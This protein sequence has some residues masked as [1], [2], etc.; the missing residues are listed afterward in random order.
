MRLFSGEH[1][2]TYRSK[3]KEPLQLAV[4]VSF[5]VIVT[6]ILWVLAVLFL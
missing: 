3:D 4:V 6:A 1:K 2:P 5:I